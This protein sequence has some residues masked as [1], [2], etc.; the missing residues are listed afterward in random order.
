MFHNLLLCLTAAALLTVSGN[1][2]ADSSEDDI[3]IPEQTEETDTKTADAKRKE[4]V[5][6]VTASAEHIKTYLKKIGEEDGFEVYLKDKDFDDELW[7][8]V[9]GKPKKKSEYTDEQ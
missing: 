4:S 5:E 1:A 7:E 2:Y 3:T 9:G 6:N 8:A